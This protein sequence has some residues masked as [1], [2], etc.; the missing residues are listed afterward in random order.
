MEKDKSVSQHM[1]HFFS[2]LIFIFL[3]SSILYYLNVQ[4]RLVKDIPL[5][6]F[7]LLVLATFR[8]IR[9]FTYDIVMDFARDYFKKFDS[10]PGKTIWQLL[11]C[12]WCSG[13]WVALIIFALYFFHPVFWYFILVLALAGAASFVQITIWRIG[14]E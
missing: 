1:W 8:M 7:F 11:D 10:G 12:P 5:F 14:R 4:N 2:M 13:V 9:L 3:F 6:D